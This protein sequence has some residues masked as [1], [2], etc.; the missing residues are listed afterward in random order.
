M[1]DGYVKVSCES[2]SEITQ[3]CPH[4]VYGSHKVDIDRGRGRLHWFAILEF[5]FQ[6]RADFIHVS[7]GNLEGR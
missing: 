7:V 3:T 1:A 6:K 4:T 5:W 2:L